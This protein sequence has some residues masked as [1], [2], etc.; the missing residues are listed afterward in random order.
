MPKANDNFAPPAGFQFGTFKN[1]R[2][3]TIRYGHVQTDKT[4][5]LGTLVLGPGYGETIEKFYELIGDLTK[6]GYNIYIM[7]WMGQGGSQ[8]KDLNDTQK[9]YD[10]KNFMDHYCDDLHQFTT[11]V[12]DVP[13]DQKLG[14]MGFSMGGHVGARFVERHNY[15]FDAIS[16]NAAFFD[17]NSRGVP[18]AAV[19]SVAKMYRMRGKGD[20]YV[21]MGG[22]WNSLRHEFNKNTKTSDAGRLRRM[23]DLYE[24]KQELQL[25]D[26]TVNW[27]HHVLPSIKDLNKKETL[28]KII[29]PAFIAAAGRDQ[30]V[31]VPAQKRAAKHMTT[32]AYR[33]YPYAKHEIWI[34]RN[35][36]RDVWLKD[37]KDFFKP[38]M[39]ADM[40]PVRIGRLVLGAQS[41]GWSQKRKR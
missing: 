17:M 30:T 11:Q 19:G 24:Q 8:R 2:G 18:R 39:Q 9:P 20:D 13:E 38:I 33:R 40:K 25:G 29:T 3:Q 41:L 37:V 10:V 16:F 5:A 36:I 26:F 35:S 6:A 31:S 28:R 27:V 1:V 21:P 15:I 12:I 4:N 32:A 14:Y 34:E 22:P 7:D 23:L